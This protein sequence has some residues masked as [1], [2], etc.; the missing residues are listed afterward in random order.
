MNERDETQTRKLIGLLGLAR[1][2]GQLAVGTTAVEKLVR[3]GERP[4]VVLATDAG[5]A[6]VQRV[7]RWDPLRGVVTG[8]VTGAELATAFGRE[9]LSVVGTAAPD[10][11]RGIRKLGI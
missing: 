5:A 4:L 3:R 2:A 8:A 6:L 11:I 9:K 1:R 10:F 7:E